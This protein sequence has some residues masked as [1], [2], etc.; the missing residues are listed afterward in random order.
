MSISLPPIVMVESPEIATAGT[1]VR[2]PESFLTGRPSILPLMVSSRWALLTALVV[3]AACW[4][5]PAASGSGSVGFDDEQ[6]ERRKGRC[7]EEGDKDGEHSAAR[8][9]GYIVRVA[10]MRPQRHGQ[11][12]PSVRTRGGPVDADELR[13]RPLGGDDRRR[14]RR[15]ARPDRDRD[16]PAPRPGPDPRE[17]VAAA[18]R[19]PGARRQIP[20]R[21]AESPPAGRTAGGSGP[22][23]ALASVFTGIVEGW[24]KW[25]AGRTR[26][27]RPVRHPRARRHRRCPARR[28]DR[29]ERRLPDRGRGAPRWPVQRRCDGRDLGTA[30]AWPPSRWAAR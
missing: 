12:V 18:C 8:L 15:R 3:V 7:G 26:R 17:R 23:A 29:R 14:G 16:M 5:S 19:G 20:A 30:P 28:L 6:P 22:V 24:A 4:S 13:F 27:L 1:L 9:H 10:V 25:S 21:G 11:R 2:S